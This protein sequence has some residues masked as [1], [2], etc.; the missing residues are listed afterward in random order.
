MTTGWRTSTLQGGE[1]IREETDL[2]WGE[3]IIFVALIAWLIKLVLVSAFTMVELAAI[4]IAFVMM[5][6]IAFAVLIM[7]RTILTRGF[8]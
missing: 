2:G 6:I 4:L 3:W 5:I 7:M 8:E 1:H